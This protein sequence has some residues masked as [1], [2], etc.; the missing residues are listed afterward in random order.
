VCEGEVL[1]LFVT[2]VCESMARNISEWHNTRK[3][4]DSGMEKETEIKE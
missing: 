4:K 1:V 2:L 3:C